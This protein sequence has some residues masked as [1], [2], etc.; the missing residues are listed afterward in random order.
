[1]GNEPSAETAA[2]WHEPAEV[3]LPFRDQPHRRRVVPV[4]HEARLPPAPSAGHEA[5]KPQVTLG[6]S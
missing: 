4:G 6:L 1:M 3:L 2:A 5:R